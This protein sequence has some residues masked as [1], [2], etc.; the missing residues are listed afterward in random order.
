MPK[1]HKRINNMGPYSI[2]SAA[3]INYILTIFYIFTRSIN[4]CQN[5]II[6]VNIKKN[7]PIP[8]LLIRPKKLNGLNKIGI[9]NDNNY[10]YF[11]FIILY[12]CHIRN[13]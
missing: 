3:N 12:I 13:K 8:N 7:R 1:I 5:E 2:I 9:F 11:R 4:I 6:C 10:S